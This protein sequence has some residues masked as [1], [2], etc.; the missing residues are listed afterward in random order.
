MVNQRG[1]AFSVFE[2]M[3][4]AIVAIAILFV[5]LPIINNITTPTGDATTT[6]GNSLSSISYG[7]KDTGVFQIE[8]GYTIRSSHFAAKGVDPCSFIFGT[9][10]FGSQITN[11]GYEEGSD[12]ICTTSITNETSSPLKAKAT[13]VCEANVDDLEE[14]I[15]NAKMDGH[16]EGGTS[17]IPTE[18]EEAGFD[19]LCV[20]ILNRSG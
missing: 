1:Q 15:L 14:S 10:K 5:L 11:T 13:I 17:D 8:A 3:I 19:K 4:A 12:G 6:I 9:A 18:W 20:V 7:K 2:L 16:F